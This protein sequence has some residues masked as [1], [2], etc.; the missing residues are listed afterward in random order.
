M[1][2]S[3]R[4][5]SQALDWL[6]KAIPGWRLHGHLVL[7]HMKQAQ[8]D[9]DVARQAMETARQLAIESDTELDDV[10]VE[11]HTARLSLAQGDLGA[12]LRWAQARRASAVS[13]AGSP[14]KDAEALIRSELMI[15]IER[16][17]LARVYV[18]NDQAGEALTIL[19]P[20]L[21]AAAQARTL[22]LLKT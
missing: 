4:Y 10:L 8:G 13:A 1:T 2:A 11:A 22:G 21:E 15:E 16:A 5:L 14:A 9:G 7:A 18:A 3:A 12:A 17:M 6:T 19:K 20:L